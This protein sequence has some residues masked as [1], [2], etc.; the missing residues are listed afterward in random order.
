MNEIFNNFKKSIDYDQ[1]LSWDKII[2]EYEENFLGSNKHNEDFSYSLES[3]YS[4]N[5]YNDP[6][7]SILSIFFDNNLLKNNDKN[8]T[9]VNK[10][11]MEKFQK[12]NN[13]TIIENKNIW[14]INKCSDS[15]SKPFLRFRLKK[16]LTDEDIKNLL[17]LLADC[18]LKI[19][20]GGNII[21]EISKLLF[22]FLI[23]EK[24]SQEIKIF[25]VKNFLESNTIEE[26]K[27][28]ILK[29][30]DK[31]CIINQKYYVNNCDD[32]YLDIPL[33]I[34]F[35]SYNISTILIAIPY[36]DVEY[37]LIIPPHT[38][39]LIN[40]YIDFD[41]N[42]SGVTLMFEEIIYFNYSSK[43]ILAQNKYEFIKMNFE[44]EYIHL[45]SPSNNPPFYSNTIEIQNNHYSTKFIFIIVRQQ[46]TINFDTGIINKFDSDINISELPQ[47]KNVILVESLHN[48]NVSEQLKEYEILL[49]NIWV[50]QFENMVIYGIAADGI[51]N[52]S[53]W[54]KVMSEGVKDIENIIL[55]ANYNK[56][57]NSL[58]NLNTNNY[59]E[60]YKI[61]NLKNI[62][63]TWT[64]SYIPVNIE[65]IYITQKLQK[66]MSGITGDCDLLYETRIY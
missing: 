32:I 62:K 3:D 53:D 26:I 38:I 17:Y 28:K 63:I 20:M 36:H 47:I 46:E 15:I 51:S 22:V 42:N 34:D 11:I 6:N 24:L 48:L 64:D 55:N 39:N 4:F 35:F 21:L 31:S 23:C 60:I 65:I 13:Q 8:F 54:I 40:K 7:Q 49:E 5:N 44:L 16:N 10:N 2:K 59:N 43:M 19:L 37:N 52:M 45:W 30:T 14:I 29:Y 56:N 33:L 50:G 41:K 18:S 61:V 9:C 27:K 66:I 1:N 12:K 25:N 57:N 58:N